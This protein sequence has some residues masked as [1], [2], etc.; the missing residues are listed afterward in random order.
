LERS[1]RNAEKSLF[2]LLSQ[3]ASQKI[4]TNKTTIKPKAL[5]AL[6]V[7]LITGVPVKSY[8]SKLFN[9]FAFTKSDTTP[10]EDTTQSDTSPV[11]ETKNDAN[12]DKASKSNSS[13]LFNFFA[14]TKSDNTPV[15]DTTQ[16]DTSPVADT[17]SNKY[18]TPLK[19]TKNDETNDKASNLI[20]L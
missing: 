14:F 3:F 15:K 9:F 4:K 2:G 12:N 6:P 19:D 7:F 10:A 16:I 13:K 1:K 20:S 8:S 5:T 17:T 18:T 11:K